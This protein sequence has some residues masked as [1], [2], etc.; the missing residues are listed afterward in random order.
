MQTLLHRASICNRAVIRLSRMLTLILALSLPS[1]AQIQNGQF[2]GVVMDPSGA[3]IPG[4]TLTVKNLETGLTL[5]TISN[6][7]GLYTAREVPIGSYKITVEVR[8][9]K[10]VIKTDLILNAGTIQRVD[11]KLPIGGQVE[12]VEV[13]GGAVPVNTESARLSETVSAQQIA[14]LPLNGRNVY[15]LIQQAPGAIN[16]T[17]LIFENGANTVVNGVRE[18][19][20]GFLINGVSN[21][22]LSG[23]YVN[24]PIQDTVQE[25]QLLTLNNSAEFGN[26]AG[27]TTNLVTKSGTNDYHGSAWW[28]V[29]NDVFDAN[30]FFLNQQAVRK[31]PLRFNQFGGTLGGPSK[32]DKFF[33]FASYQGEHFLISAAPVP[34][35]AE[36][37][38]LFGRDMPFLLDTV[39]VLQSQNQRFSST[40]NLFQGNEASVRLDYNFSPNDRVFS[41][42]NWSRA[43]DKFGQFSEPTALRGFTL[44]FKAPTPNFQLSYIHNLGP[45]ALNEVRAGYAGNI[46][47]IGVTLPGVPGIGIAD[48][49]IGFGSYNGY[50]QFFKE[51]IYT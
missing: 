3:V 39:A 13:V 42:M 33:F 44:P 20:N 45:T 29:R 48:G 35:F 12:T 10:T 21:K 30:S 23:G 1:L 50:P 5:T 6:D 36:T 26:S 37:G 40:G 24:L 41:Q 28:F 15:D 16:A 31:P 22:G 25:F 46:S 14:N 18:N 43:T 27:A 32:K 7:S 8:G 47:D 49:T 2:T 38:G 17:G 51:N 34:A 9:F 19:F 11:F 4:A